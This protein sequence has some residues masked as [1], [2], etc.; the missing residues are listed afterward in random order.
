[1]QHTANRDQAREVVGIIAQ[2]MVDTVNSSREPFGLPGGHL[3]AHVCGHLSLNAFN[4]VMNA[5]V[6]CG[7][8]RKAGD[9]YLPIRAV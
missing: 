6:I 4:Q 5:L 7:K 3:Y 1:M 9:C 8:V 2:A